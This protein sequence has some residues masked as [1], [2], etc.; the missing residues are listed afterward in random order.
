MNKKK[1]WVILYKNNYINIKYMN[2]IYYFILK[3]IKNNIGKLLLLVIF[4]LIINFLKINVISMITASIIDAINGKN[5]TETYKI[6]I[7]FICISIFYLTFQSFYGYLQVKILSIIRYSIRDDLVKYI[8]LKNSNKYSEINFSVLNSPIYRISNSI[9]YI[10]NLIVSFLIPNITMILIIFAYFLYKNL[11]LGSVFFIGN[12]LVFIYIY[13]IRNII[14]KYNSIYENYSVK[15]ETYIIE[16]LNNIDKIIFRGNIDDEIKNQT[17]LSE[18]TTN[19]SIDFYNVTIYHTYI[20]SLIIMVTILIIIYLMIKLFYDKNMNS[21][22][23]VTFFTVLLLYRDL[24]I[25][26]INRLPDLI[27]FYGKSDSIVSLFNKMSDKDENVEDLEKL[28]NEKFNKYNLD[29]KNIE[30]KDIYFKYDKGKKYIL[31]NF[32]LTLN[33]D[34]KILGIVGSSGNG[35]S[36]FVKLL[37]KIY[38]Y[39]GDISIDGVNIKDID[40]RYLRKN[41]IYVNQNSKLFDIK[42]IDNLL[43]GCNNSNYESCYDQLKEVIDNDKIAHIFNEIDIMNKN[44]GS[45]GE[46]LSGGQRQIVNLINGLITPSKITILDEPTNGLDKDLKKNIIEI[47]KYFKKYKQCII[48]ISHDKD[49][50]DIFDETINI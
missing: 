16:L 29:F 21:T 24:I 25:E 6:F 13:L 42:V 2:V 37:I 8:L 14:L 3:F 41:I 19:S 48:I 40:F 31:E 26:T 33:V 45:S 22:L 49:I 47:I 28:F 36:T 43:Y 12:I 10:F 35:K 30:Y 32:N 50:Y 7:Y 44:A 39:K 20:M 17:N 9:F 34:N 23:F 27:E 46:N 5:K 1:V 18:K 38:K 15:S 11:K 4:S